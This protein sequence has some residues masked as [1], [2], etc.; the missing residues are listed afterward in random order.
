MPLH[1][2]LSKLLTMQENYNTTQQQNENDL[3]LPYNA[4]AGDV[5]PYAAMMLYQSKIHVFQRILNLEFR[6]SSVVG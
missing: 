6:Y 5:D 2:S 1:K 3:I 4:K